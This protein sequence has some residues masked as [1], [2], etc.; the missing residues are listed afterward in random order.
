MHYWLFWPFAK[1]LCCYGETARISRDVSFCVFER[2]SQMLDWIIADNVPTAPGAFGDRNWKKWTLAAILFGL[3]IREIFPDFLSLSESPV[4]EQKLAV[5]LK[6]QLEVPS[7][8]LT[9]IPK[10]ALKG[11]D[12]G[13][14]EPRLGALVLKFLEAKADAK[15]IALAGGI[16]LSS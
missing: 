5:K 7:I 8:L 10:F 9:K 6:E 11:I 14:D 12:V 13:D 3:R 4:R 1:S 16:G 2:A 15:D